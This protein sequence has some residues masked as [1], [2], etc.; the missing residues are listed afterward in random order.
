MPLSKTPI[1]LMAKHPAPGKVKTRLVGPDCSPDQAAAVHLTFLRHLVR[2]LARLNPA[3]LVCC[4]DPAD[5]ASDMRALFPEAGQLTF[6]PQSGGDL[7]ARIAGAATALWSGHDRLLFLGVDSPDVPLAHLFKAA[8]LADQAP[9]S[10]SPTDD[11]GYWSLGLQA[12]VDAEALLRGI[13][14]STGEEAVA[15]LASAD[16]L[17]FAAATGLMWDDVD[18]PADLRRLIARLERSQTPADETLLSNLRGVLPAHWF[19]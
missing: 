1:V 10:L 9:V 2:R 6:L 4:F 18:R 12:H 5:R 17:G 13:P 7:G 15:T 11:G 19:S 8:E 14:W 3:A 16:R